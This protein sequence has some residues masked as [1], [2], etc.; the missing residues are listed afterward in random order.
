[1]THT[2]WLTLTEAAQHIRAKHPRLIADAIK[3][4]DLRAYS[5]GKHDPRI[6]LADL[7]EW[8]KSR[9]WTPA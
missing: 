1:M 3:R 4:G 9:A 2:Q 5:Y 8:I 7:D 6:D